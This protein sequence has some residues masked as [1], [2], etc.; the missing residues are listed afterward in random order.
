MTILRSVCLAVLLCAI[1]AAAGAAEAPKDQTINDVYP[2]FATA[3]LTHARLA[4]LPSGVI[5]RCGEILVVQNDLDG[6][7]DLLKP[8]M[9]PKVEKD[10]VYL[11]EDTIGQML[12]YSE[13]YDWSV[14]N[15]VVKDKVEELVAAYLAARTKSI[16]VS[17]AEAKQFY[18]SSK[19]DMPGVEFSEVKGDIS[20]MLVSSK[21][22]AAV[23]AYIAD[24]G[25]KYDIE[26]DKKWAAAQYPDIMSNPVE[27]A[28][29][30]GKPLLVD[31]GS[32]KCEPCTRLAPILDGIKK[33]Y[34]DKLDILLVDV[35]EDMLL[36]ARYGAASIPM[37]VFYDKSG[38]EIFRHTGFYSKANIVAELAE[39]GVK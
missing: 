19:I 13:A 16:T 18:D 5:L 7:L 11:L 25:T 36:G 2:G 30:S 38:K 9:R 39:I 10:K 8:E 4:D 20:K 6:R 12:L 29:K 21:R 14:K 23:T 3:A 27:K 1:A 37:Q 17:E 31:F 35:D 34:A 24:L 22:M 28:R 26:V 33:E 32:T 15:K